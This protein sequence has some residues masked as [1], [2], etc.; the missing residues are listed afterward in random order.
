MFDSTA[1][2]QGSLSEIPD[3]II[4]PKDVLKKHQLTSWWL[5]QKG[6]Y[7]SSDHYDELNKST[8]H[9]NNMDS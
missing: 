5:Q 6:V 7:V 1:L 4:M 2:L 8:K 3:T 9:N